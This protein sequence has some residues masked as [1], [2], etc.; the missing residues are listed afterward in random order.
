[1]DKK[2]KRIH[3]DPQSTQPREILSKFQPQFHAPVLNSFNGHEE[4]FQKVYSLIFIFFLVIVSG[5]T[6]IYA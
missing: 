6:Y 5:H 1:M 2:R 4:T 3:E